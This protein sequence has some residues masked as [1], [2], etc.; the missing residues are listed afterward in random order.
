[1]ERTRED[2]KV[3]LSI[4]TPDLGITEKAY[5]TPQASQIL[6]KKVVLNGLYTLAED[7]EKVAISAENGNTVISAEC[8]HGQPV[9]IV[10]NK[11]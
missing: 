3:V 2:Q 10:L 8:Q 4:C 1:M 7:N 5:T 6:K 11:N 9:E